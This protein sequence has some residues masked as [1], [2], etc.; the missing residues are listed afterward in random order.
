MSDAPEEKRGPRPA[1]VGPEQ[2]TSP[3]IPYNGDY[4]KP[5]VNAFPSSTN[6]EN[7]GFPAA[8][9][10][11]SDKST[12]VGKSYSG[13][14]DASAAFTDAH[15][16]KNK[17]GQ[18]SDA[19]KSQMKKLADDTNG[20][21]KSLQ[22]KD[23]SKLSSEDLKTLEKTRTT[24]DNILN[25]SK[26]AKEKAHVDAERNEKKRP[27]T[28]PQNGRDELEPNGPGPPRIDRDGRPMKEEEEDLEEEE[29][30]DRGGGNGG[31]HGPRYK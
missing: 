21:L 15:E 2:G 7:L 1:E 11:F 16:D 4:S 22:G 27:I 19:D 10:L 23:L 25:A 13:S 9:Q 26:A 31:G 30:G 14:G 6:V 5:I 20:L 3:L 8:G 17:L 28:E 18:L 24:I 29:Q 12:V